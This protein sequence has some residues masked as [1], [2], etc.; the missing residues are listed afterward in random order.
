[1]LQHQLKL[2][3]PVL[4]AVYPDNLN[5]Q[6]KQ[7]Q[8]GEQLGKCACDCEQYLKEEKTSQTSIIIYSRNHCLKSYSYTSDRT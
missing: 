4:T 7:K 1:M 5:K 8:K 6:N 2:S 3:K